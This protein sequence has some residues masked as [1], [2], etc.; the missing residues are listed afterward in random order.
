MAVY[1]FLGKLTREGRMTLKE[2]PQRS[3]APTEYAKKLGL[4]VI[5]YYATLGPY[6]YV[7]ILEG[8]DDPTAY[9]KLI[10][11]AS[12]DGNISWTALPA[13]RSQ[14]FAR[15]VQQVPAE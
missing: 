9:F 15:V 12:M 8:P 6:D 1:I 13:L 2:G 5:D 14:D 4:K 3:V 7:S 10:T 11:F